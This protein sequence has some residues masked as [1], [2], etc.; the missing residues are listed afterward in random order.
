LEKKMDLGILGGMET[1]EIQGQTMIEQAGKDRTG[2][3][4]KGFYSV[5]KP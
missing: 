4:P 5:L 1:P 3:F 2:G